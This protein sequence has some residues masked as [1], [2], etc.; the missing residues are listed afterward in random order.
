MPIITA[1]DGASI[2]FSDQGSGTAVL[3]LHGWMMSKKVW[4][5]QLPLSSGL[6]IITLDLRGHGRSDSQDFSYA[7]CLGD[8]EELLDHLDT[9]NIVIV[10]WSMGSQ[11]AIKG[12]SRLKERISGMILVGGTSC[13]CSSAGYSGGLPANEPR[14]MAIRLKRDYHEAS[15]HFFRSMFSTQEM[16]S[17]DLDDIAAKTTSILPPLKISLSALKE[18]A[19]TDLRHL[20]PD[21][22]IPVRLIHGAEDGI[23]PAG[24]AEFM[25]G[26][27][28]RATLKIIPA[29]GHAP[30]L[31]AAE[32]FNAE[33][34]RFIRN[35]NGKD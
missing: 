26:S 35:L 27:L 17:A 23:C 21:I 7:A 24:A 29:S 19:D 6:R 20:L 14:G 15:R 30:F 33:V 11:L 1:K 8:I 22:N 28:P 32:G 4:H 31:S 25:A 16:A 12:F 18:L 5:F 3:F 13:F 9:R 2:S 10:G 34:S